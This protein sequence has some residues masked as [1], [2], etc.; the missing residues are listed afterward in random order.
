MGYF[1]ES[2]CLKQK[3]TQYFGFSHSIEGNMTKKLTKNEFLRFK[4]IFPP[5]SCI[6]SMA[7]WPAAA[8]HTHTPGHDI[9]IG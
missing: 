3:C 6:D 9:I 7:V 1:K 5:Y 2:N 8:N 4:L